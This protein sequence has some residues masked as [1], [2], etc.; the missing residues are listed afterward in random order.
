MSVAVIE[1]LFAIT[2]CVFTVTDYKTQIINILYVLLVVNAKEL[3]TTGPPQIIGSAQ[4]V[5]GTVCAHHT[6][7]LMSQ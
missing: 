6:K 4:Y 2:K 7:K 5:R 1:Y 3:V